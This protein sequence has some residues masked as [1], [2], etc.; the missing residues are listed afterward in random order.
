MKKIVIILII[1][2][3]LTGCKDKKV[4]KE[5]EEMVNMKINGIDV[6]IEL[7]NNDT[8]KELLKHLPLNYEMQELNGNEKYVYFDFSLPTSSFKPKEIHIGDVYLFGDNCLV[9]FYQDFKT[10][11]SYTKIGHITNLPDLGTGKITIEM[12]N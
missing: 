5:N 4:I 10:T 6:S 2:M 9:I 12:K 1:F 7:E 3:V 8:V 11:Y